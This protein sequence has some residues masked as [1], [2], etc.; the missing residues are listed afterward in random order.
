M[1]GKAGKIREA[2]SRAAQTKGRAVGNRRG[3]ISNEGQKTG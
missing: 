2:R 3:L 1:R